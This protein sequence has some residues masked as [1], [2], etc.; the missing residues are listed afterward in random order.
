MLNEA[1]KTKTLGWVELTK[2]TLD[3]WDGRGMKLNG[4]IHMELKFGIHVI[5]Q[6]IYNSNRLNNISCKFVDLAYKVV[7]NNLSFNLAKLLLN[8]FNQNMERIKVSKNNPCKFDSLL[9][10]LFFYIQNFFPSKF[11]VV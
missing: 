3:V 9:T 7:K 6:K 11:F 10:C 1:K 5:A 2:R 8:Q 4:V